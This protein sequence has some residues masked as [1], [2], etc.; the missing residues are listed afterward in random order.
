MDK[1]PRPCS[2]CG[3][4]VYRDG[5]C[6]THFDA[7]ERRRGN[8]HQR[9]YGQ[10]HETVFR[11][12]V[13]RRNP[14]CVICEEHPSTVADHYPRTRRTLERLGLD[15]D[16]PDYGRGLCASCHSWATASAT[17]SL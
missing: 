5:K 2:T 10:R 1:P 17:H 7:Y 3:R 11:A 12:E 4:P 6:R 9:G 8:S 14:I 15:P 16:H 13:L